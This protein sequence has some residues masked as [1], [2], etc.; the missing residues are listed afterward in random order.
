M[1]KLRFRMF[2][3]IVM[4]SM[5]LFVNAQVRN[6]AINGTLIKGSFEEKILELVNEA[7]RNAGV[8]ELKLDNS[9]M[10]ISRQ[11]AVELGSYYDG[12]HLRPNLNR[13]NDAFYEFGFN[14]NFAGENIAYGYG[15]SNYTTPEGVVNVWLNSTLHRNNI[16]NERYKSLGLGIYK[17]SNGY[18]YWV[19]NFSDALYSEYTPS[20]Q[21]VEENDEYTLKYEDTIY[22]NVEYN[23]ILDVNLNIGDKKDINYYVNSI[24]TGSNSKIKFKLLDWISNNTDVISIS[25]NGSNVVINANKAGSSSISTTYGNRDISFLVN[26]TGQTDLNS[27]LLYTLNYKN[28]ETKLDVSDDQE[29]STLILDVDGISRNSITQFYNDGEIVN[30][31][32]ISIR[33]CQDDV[34]IIPERYIS[35]N[36]L[37]ADYIQNDFIF[38]NSGQT[39]I[40]AIFE[41]GLKVKIPVSVALFKFNNQE[42]N[43]SIGENIFSSI[44]TDLDESYSFKSLNPE[45]A[46][47]DNDGK[48]SGISSGIAYIECISDSGF[49]AKAKVNVKDSDDVSINIDEYNIEF[50][51]GE[52]SIIKY[53]VIPNDAEVSFKSSDE[54]IVTVDKDGKL[55]G[56]SAGT[57]TIYVT[58]TTNKGSIVKEVNVSVKSK[59]I[60]IT[61]IILNRDNISLKV[62]ETFNI[63]AL[64]VPDNAS[65]KSLTFESSDRM[66]ADVDGNGK[67]TAINAGD[68]VITVTSGNGIS[69]S[70]RVTVLEKDTDKPVI[71]VDKEEIELSI[72]DTEIINITVVDDRKLTM[73]SDDPEIA[74]IDDDGKITAI[75]SGNTTIHITTS[76]GDEKIIKVHVKEERIPIT[77]ITLNHENVTLNENESITIEAKINPDNT[78]DKLDLKWMSEDNSVAI[79]DEYGKITAIHEGS[80]VI[81]VTSVNG[82]YSR[83]IVNVTKK[84]IPISDIEVIED[85]ITLN[86]GDKKEINVNI[87]PSNTTD[88]KTLSWKSNDTGIAIVDNNGIIT[89]IHEGSAIITVTS[90]NGISHDIKVLVKENSIPIQ[91]IKLDKNNVELIEGEFTSVKAQVIPI[92]TTSSTDLTWVSSNTNV[93]TVDNNGKITAIH[94]GNA[95]ITVT[96]VNGISVTIKVIVHKKSIP[97]SSIQLEKENYILYVGDYTNINAI[98]YPNDTTDSKSL[99]WQSDNPLIA[100]VDS[101][102]KVIAKNA[103]IANITITSINGIT[104]KVKIYVYDIKVSDITLNIHDVVLKDDK[105]IINIEAYSPDN[106]IIDSNL[107]EWSS[108]NSNV[109]IVY[110]NKI[111]PIGYGEALITAHYGDVFDTCRV[112]VPKNINNIPIGTITDMIKKYNDGDSKNVLVNTSDILGITLNSEIQEIFDLYD[113]FRISWESSNNEILTIE[114]G[115]IRFL[116]PGRASVS[117]SFGIYKTTLYYNIYDISVDVSNDIITVGDSIKINTIIHTPTTIDKN[118]IFTVN[119]SSIVSIDKNGVVTGLKPGVAI[120]HIYS[121]DEAVYKTINITVKEKDISSNKFD[122]VFDEDKV[123]LDTDNGNITFKIANIEISDNDKKNYISLNEELISYYRISYE[124]DNSSSLENP[125]YNISIPFNY[126]NSKYSSVYLSYVSQGR[127]VRTIPSKVENGYIS[128]QTNYLGDFVLCGILN[129]KEYNNDFNNNSVNPNTGNKIIIYIISWIIAFISLLLSITTILVKKKRTN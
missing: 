52:N 39:T 105:Q 25:R 115:K 35:D 15:I 8:S 85:D 86:V 116:K 92:N 14:H 99:I 48:I 98:V 49:I 1:S 32:P 96:S 94:S 107:I 111:I 79:V 12:R 43:V 50:V 82:V 51:E 7:R 23:D 64:V 30:K 95:L 127:V 22:P 62:D 78:T 57:A 4:L 90:T 100:S 41:N 29:L 36:E 74:T 91:E 2:I 114:N 34:C 69:K 61:D 108:S 125:I 81:I 76:L 21:Y 63:E 20:R 26:V 97:I 121:L 16:L 72:G 28:L 126:D 19:Q 83:V 54:R 88:D 106:A 6:I 73:Y 45:I 56:I 13:F 47:V 102:G 103:G 120:I 89:A 128:F 65:N 42:Y 44:I 60:S 46:T 68:A 37:V 40:T 122:V 77:S 66:V 5:P 31:S 112:V 59:E 101:N 119:D 80:T 33:F 55:H 17:D 84:Q 53:S 24:N 104:A 11:R 70:I 123:V 109:A 117:V 118:C 38:N 110:N 93:V 58:V 3:L 27:Y 71:E 67:I 113:N 124:L 75:S 87:K 129:G 9:L 10:N 18:Y